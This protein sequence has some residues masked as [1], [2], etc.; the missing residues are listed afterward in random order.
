MEGEVNHATVCFVKI[1]EYFVHFDMVLSG[2][3]VDDYL[4]PNLVGE[5]IMWTRSIFFKE[6][7]KTAL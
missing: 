3:L 5:N 6:I 7:M 4:I 1:T 2:K